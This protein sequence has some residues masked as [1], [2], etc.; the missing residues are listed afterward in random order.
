[1]RKTELNT[2]KKKPNKQILPALDL[3]SI[4]LSFTLHV[5]WEDDFIVLGEFRGRIS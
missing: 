4:V 1:M 5:E 2:L 3:V